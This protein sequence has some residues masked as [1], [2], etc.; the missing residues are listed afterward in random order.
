MTGSR[1]LVRGARLGIAIAVRPLPARADRDRYYCEFVAELY[2]LDPSAQRRQVAGYLAESLA[3]RAAVGGGPS[4]LPLD[5]P[6]STIRRVVVCR[7]LRWHRW[8]VFRT[9]DGARYSACAI[10]GKFPT[11]TV[12]RD[13]FTVA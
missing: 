8:R 10:C 9:P 4:G 12:S 7:L 3:L 1:A 5:A 11:D 2:G 13:G 6:P